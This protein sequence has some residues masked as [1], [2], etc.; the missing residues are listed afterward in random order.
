MEPRFF[1]F[2]K[3]RS[4][5]TTSQINCILLQ[6]LSWINHKPQNYKHRQYTGCFI[7][8]CMITNI[9]NKKT[10][11]P[12]LMELF[13]AAGK[14]K[15]F[16]LTTRHVR[17]VHH[18]WHST[19][20]YDI[21]VLATHASTFFTAAMICAFRS[22]RSRGNGGTYTWSLTYPQRKKSQGVMSGDLGGQSNSGWSFPDTR[23]I[24]RPGNNSLLHCSCGMSLCHW[25]APIPGND[26][27]NSLS[28]VTVNRNQA[29]ACDLHL[30][31]LVPFGCAM[32]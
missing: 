5:W 18:G 4:F 30:T 11:G 14:L 28:L 22:A 12:T 9:C 15:K 23:P 2:F 1:K 8:F 3:L 13:T 7:M 32:V 24:Q 10:K 25:T 17:C 26:H 29:G 19:H 16:F 31:I 20:R 6:S 27:W 21:Q